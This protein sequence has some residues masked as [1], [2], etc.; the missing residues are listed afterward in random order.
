MESSRRV[1]LPP[2]YEDADTDA[3]CQLIGTYCELITT[4]NLKGP[5][6][7]GM[8]KKTAL[9]LDRL[10]SINDRIPLSPYVSLLCLWFQGRLADL[11]RFLPFLFFLG[12]RGRVYHLDPT[13]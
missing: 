6:T 3:L 13:R 7:P 10:I 12:G 8:K 1:G 2:V 4:P 5:L 11:C 9:M